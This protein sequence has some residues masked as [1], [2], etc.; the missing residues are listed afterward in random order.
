MNGESMQ[1]KPELQLVELEP[2][3]TNEDKIKELIDKAEMIKEIIKK[4]KTG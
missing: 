1:E 4:K 3:K 2:E